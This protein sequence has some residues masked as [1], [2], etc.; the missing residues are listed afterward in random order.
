MTEKRALALLR[1]DAPGGLDWFID[2]YTAYVSAIVWNVLGPVM[3]V[4]D[5]EE[6]PNPY[7]VDGI[8]R[9]VFQWLND[10]N[11]HGQALQLADRANPEHME[12]WPVMTAVV[13]LLATL[14]G[15]WIFRE[16]DIK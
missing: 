14:I 13:I 15:Y 16:K 3:T 5:V 2:R 10:T 12:R 8:K 11:P 9:E 7:Y 1:E 4:Q 6:V